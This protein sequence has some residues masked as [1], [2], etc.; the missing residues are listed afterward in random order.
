MGILHHI[1]CVEQN[2]RSPGY[3]R[4]FECLPEFRADDSP[5]VIG[6]NRD[7][8]HVTLVIVPGWL[9]G[10][11]EQLPEKAH[12]PER[13]SLFVVLCTDYLNHLKSSTHDRRTI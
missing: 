6:P 10:H 13:S 11:A 1:A 8:G 12:D 4:N 7:T 5:G 9:K 2:S 3:A